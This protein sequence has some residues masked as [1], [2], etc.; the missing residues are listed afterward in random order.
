MTTEDVHVKINVV[1]QLVVGFPSARLSM[2]VVLLLAGT[3]NDHI[4]SCQTW[5]WPGEEP[6]NP[7]EDCEGCCPLCCG[8][9]AALAWF[10]DNPG[11]DAWLTEWLN[12]WHPDG[13]SVWQLPGGSVDWKFIAAHWK[14]GELGCHDE[15]YLMDMQET[16][17]LGK[18]AERAAVESAADLSLATLQA[19]RAADPAAENPDVRSPW[20]AV[21]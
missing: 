21:E 9:C 2:A 16:V 19:A 4:L 14:P 12:A 15:E 1:N 11:A 10:R 18:L 17:D 20:A 6:L 5:A 7:P 13:G 3:V 8:P